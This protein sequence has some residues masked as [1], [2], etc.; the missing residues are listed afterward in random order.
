MVDAGA[1]GVT[2]L[3][4]NRVVGKTD[5]SGRLLVTGLRGFQDNKISIDPTTLP[6]D[7][8]TSSTEVIAR[9]RSRSGVVA[10]FNVKTSPHDAEI[11]LTDE[12]GNPLPAG[13]KVDRPGGDAT[14]V[15]YDG[16]AYLED[17]AQHNALKVRA[18]DR[19]CLVAFDFTPARGA[20][21]PTIGPLVCKPE[22]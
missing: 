21:R 1:P 3:E 7:A 15:G 17:L 14:V 19:T 9:P 22:R 10:D 8:Q 11:V 4:D 18:N 20:A 2:V 5:A 16:R 6:L 13:A 12:A